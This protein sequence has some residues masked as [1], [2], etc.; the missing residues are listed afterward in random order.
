MGG[1]DC[2]Y[3]S[4]TLPGQRLSP[5]PST[6]RRWSDSG[7]CPPGTIRAEPGHD[8][9]RMF[10]ALAQRR[11]QAIWIIGTNPAASMPNLP[12]GPRGA[13]K[14][15][16]GHRAGRVSPDRDDALR[17][18]RPARRRQLRAGRR[19]LQQRAARHADGAGRPAARRGQARLVVDP[20]RRAARW[21]ST[22]RMR[23]TSPADIFD[24]FA[25]STAGRPND[26][27]APVPR[28][29]APQGPAA[30]AV[31]RRWGDRSQRRYADGRFPTPSGK[32]RFWARPHELAAERTD[33]ATS[34]SS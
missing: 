16:A 9:V 13:A 25:R 31:S 20:G 21:A 6:A 19:L 12:A 8:A 27:S 23:F 11:D 14:R 10:D 29:A 28:T 3:M 33:D 17:P 2:G 15:R 18:R 5:T 24:E 34:R 26:Q 4:H 22:R 30:V 1:R 7:A 32:A